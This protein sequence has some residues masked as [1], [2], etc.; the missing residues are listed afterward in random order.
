MKTKLLVL[1]WLCVYHLGAQDNDSLKHV[2]LQ[3]KLQAFVSY[4]DYTSH[5]MLRSD[6][7]DSIHFYAGQVIGESDRMMQEIRKVIPK[8]EC[9]PVDNGYLALGMI[10]SSSSDPTVTALGVIYQSL[11]AYYTPDCGSEPAF[12]QRVQDINDF[13]R[14]LH[15][16]RKLEKAWRKTTRLMLENR[17]MQYTLGAV[18]KE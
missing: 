15:R 6:E 9:A 8:R 10:Y 5:K 3:E 7:L 2:Q 18:N 11:A 1:S 4:C 13:A 12:I 16:V 14:Q 17:N